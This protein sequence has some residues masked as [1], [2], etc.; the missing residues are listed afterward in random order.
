MDTEES[1]LLADLFDKNY[2]T[3]VKQ[4]LQMINYSSTYYDMVEDCVQ[5]AFQQ[6]MIRI[7]EVAKYENP[8]GWLSVTARLRLKSEMRL[9]RKHNKILSEKV[10]NNGEVNEQLTS[11]IDQWCRANEASEK[12]ERILAILS[13]LEQTVYQTYFVDGYSIDETAELLHMDR[14]GIRGAIDRIR[15]KAR[16]LKINFVFFVFFTWIIAL[17]SNI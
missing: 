7:D 8:A 4:C 9:I 14:T 2:D 16:T 11:Q 10:Y 5:Y 3:I 1:I 17:L 15:H 13:D 12:L 6:A